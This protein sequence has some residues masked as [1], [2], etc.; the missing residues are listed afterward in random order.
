MKADISNANGE[1]IRRKE[2]DELNAQ[3]SNMGLPESV[4]FLKKSF[5][6]SAE[7]AGHILKNDYISGTKS[8][9]GK[10]KIINHCQFHP[11][12]SVDIKHITGYCCNSHY[13]MCPLYQ[14]HTCTNTLM[15]G[16]RR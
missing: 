9:L 6:C 7:K 1:L 13:E 12:T 14:L 15:S 4:S 2:K 16:F 11:A 3:L 8:F 10:F 5:K